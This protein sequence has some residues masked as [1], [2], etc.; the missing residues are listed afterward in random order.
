MNLTKALRFFSL[1]IMTFSALLCLLYIITVSEWQFLLIGIATEDI[2]LIWAYAMTAI[3]CLGVVIFTI[4]EIFTNPKTARS[5]LISISSL[6]A[7]VALSYFIATDEIPRFL[8]SEKFNLT[9][10]D[11]KWIGA[12]LITS[13][14]LMGIATLGILYAEVSKMFNK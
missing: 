13:Y 5:A 10:G 2:L 12:S 6:T 11:V 14:I 3:A 4:A 7:V 1:G 8:G 9:P